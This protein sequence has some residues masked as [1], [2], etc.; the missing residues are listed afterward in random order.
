MFIV[1]LFMIA[2]EWTQP[3]CLST[4]EWVNNNNKRGIISVVWPSHEEKNTIQC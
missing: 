2:K 1:A 3:N 4:D